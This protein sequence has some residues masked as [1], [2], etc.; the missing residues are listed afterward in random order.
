M[1]NAPPNNN[2]RDTTSKKDYA[3]NELYHMERRAHLFESRRVKFFRCALFLFGRLALLKYSKEYK[4]NNTA[5]NRVSGVFQNKYIAAL[6]HLEHGWVKVIAICRLEE[7]G[8]LRLTRLLA[9]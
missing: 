5:K 7:F 2:K 1:L 4:L 9:L 3:L 8:F 6:A